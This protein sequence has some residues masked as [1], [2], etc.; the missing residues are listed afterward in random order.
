MP[1][2]AKTAPYPQHPRFEI[3]FLGFSAL[4]RIFVIFM[5]FFFEYSDDRVFMGI[6]VA[7]GVKDMS[8]RYD[9]IAV[10]YVSLATDALFK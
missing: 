6:P 9:L 3:G 4:R 7:L 10:V 1:A 2:T 8:M 5:A